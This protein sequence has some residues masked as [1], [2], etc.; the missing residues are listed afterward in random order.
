[1]YIYIHNNITE[2]LCV[3]DLIASAQCH[4]LTPLG[5]GLCSNDCTSPS[6]E[7]GTMMRSKVVVFF[8]ILLKTSALQASINLLTFRG[9]QRRKCMEITGN[10]MDF[11]IFFVYCLAW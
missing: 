1:M 10:L 7:H 9:D 6:T 2:T 5:G 11:R 4:A 8:V 3:M